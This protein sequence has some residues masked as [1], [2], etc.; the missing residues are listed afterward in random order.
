M[1]A[2]KPEYICVCSCAGSSEYRASW[3]NVFPSQGFINR[4]APYTDKVYVT[5][6]VTD[7]NNNEYTSLN[8]NIVFFVSGGNIS[9][10]G[11]NNSLK[12]KDTEW[13]WI[14]RQMPDAWLRKEDDI[15]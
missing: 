10:I 12:L 13:F 3:Q 9:V 14:N 1:A 7:Y 15:E 5:T 11:S 2:I 6:L 8:G 4:I